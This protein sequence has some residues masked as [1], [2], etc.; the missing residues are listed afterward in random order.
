MGAPH[1][2]SF[3]PGTKLYPWSSTVSSRGQARGGEKKWVEN[4]ILLNPS[5]YV[6][7]LCPF[8]SSIS[9]QKVSVQGKDSVVTHAFN[10]KKQAQTRPCSTSCTT[11]QAG[12]QQSPVC[13]K[14]EYSKPPEIFKMCFWSPEVHWQF[15]CS[16]SILHLD[17][18]DHSYINV[19]KIWSQTADRV[20]LLFS[21]Y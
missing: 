10:G 13:L 4:W 9:H 7:N 19:N 3:G 18:K 17:L 11:W 12:I 5:S 15:K 20:I 16:S 14:T 6:K 8:Y 1:P 2:T 21:N